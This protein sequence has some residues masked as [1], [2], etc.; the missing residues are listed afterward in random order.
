M[1]TLLILSILFYQLIAFAQTIKPRCLDGNCK[2]KIGTYMYADSSV[3][4]GSFVDKLRSGQGNITYRNKSSYDG[5]WMNDKRNG[6]GVYIDSLGNKHEGLWVDD[7]ENGKGKYTDLKGNVY[8]GSWTNGALLGYITLRY[9]NK[10]LYEGEYNNGIRGKGKF[11]YSD[12][13]VYTGN[14]AK[15]KRSGYGELVYSYDLT[16]KGNWVSNEVDGQGEF[17]LTS[18]QV[19]IAE[20]V[21]KTDKTNPS[22]SKF[23]SPDG[24]MVCYYA[25]KN[26]YYGKA[27]TGMPNGIG[28]M[29]Y[30]IGDVYEGNFEKGI[31]NGYGKLKLKDNSEYKGDW[32]NG[33]KDGFGTLTKADNS[34]VKGYWKEGNYIGNT[35]PKTSLETD[36]LFFAKGT[37]IE[38]I[39]FNIIP[40]YNFLFSLVHAPGSIV[41]GERNNYIVQTDLST[42]KSIKVLRMLN[43]NTNTTC[44]ENITCYKNNTMLKQTNVLYRKYDSNNEISVT[45]RVY[46]KSDGHY[47]EKKY[48]LN[49]QFEIEVSG[50]IETYRF[51]HNN[52]KIG[53]GIAALIAQNS[54]N[55][56]TY[57]FL[58]DYSNN[59]LPIKFDLSKFSNKIIMRSTD[60]LGI[61]YEMSNE[62]GT[63]NLSLLWIEQVI[64][65]DKFYFVFFKGDNYCVPVKIRKSDYQVTIMHESIMDIGTNKYK[66][67]SNFAE[68][69]NG[70]FF[71]PY[72][73]GFA[74]YFDTKD[75]SEE[76]WQYY[77]T[78]NIYD[79][80]L[81]KNNSFKVEKSKKIKWI[82]EYDKYLI[83]GGFTYEQ[84]YLGYSNPWI[85]VIDKS[86]KLTTFDKVIAQKN[87][88]V[89]Y[90]TSDGE[91][92]IVISVSS[93][94]CQLL[95]TDSQFETKII[96]D[97]LSSIGVFENN[98]FSDIKYS[99]NDNSFSDNEYLEKPSLNDNKKEGLEINSNSIRIEPEFPGGISAQLQFIQKN[100]KYPNIDLSNNVSGKV[101]VTFNVEADGRLTNIRIT[102]GLTETTNAEAVKVIKAM[103]NWIPGT[104]DGLKTRQEFTLPINFSLE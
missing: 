40:T 30:A 12:G 15:N 51:A 66:P 56:K 47:F 67:S 8:E 25:N 97:K 49:Y 55:K 68:S 36:V 3:Y 1:K 72:S 88:E 76:I 59:V 7:K 4:R 29:K 78:L 28:T 75:D 21:W 70:M 85:R 57:L 103:P 102:K 48:Q 5:Q 74:N 101:E 95:D 32:K 69:E 6:N 60:N 82:Y 44:D 81:K 11:T 16:Y 41:G 84:G 92:K 87:G 37:K 62:K 27:E 39:F 64:Q 65:N 38:K 10:S 31:Y 91:G 22:D 20:G 61:S 13:S 17:Y 80:E 35:K 96:I 99:Y 50:N 33:L 79:I 54:L 46:S 58:H 90:I 73:Q 52:Y 34:A 42:K 53:N 9:K 23:I 104:V 26:L 19:K 94:C 18:S 14:F 83:L 71:L 100:F 2:N 24:L 77:T 98:L 89:G 86:T 93:A 43:E 63:R 45:E